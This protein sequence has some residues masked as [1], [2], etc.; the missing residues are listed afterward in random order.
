M[1]RRAG[2]PLGCGSPYDPTRD[3][4]LA[5]DMEAELA[6]DVELYDHPT[7]GRIRLVDELVHPAGSL[8]YTAAELEQ[9]GAHGD[10]PDLVEWDPA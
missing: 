1:S 5:Q 8:P 4:R 10:L 7:K 2:R 3:V 9:A 6:A